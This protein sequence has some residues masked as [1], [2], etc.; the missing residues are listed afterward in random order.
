MFGFSP[1]AKS[2]NTEKVAS[3]Q[4]SRRGFIRGLGV[5]AASA[6]AFGGGALTTTAAKADATLDLEIL[7]FAL[8]LEY[9]EAE[10][11]LLAATGTGLAPADI[12][13]NP[14]I[15]TGGHKVSFQN[16]LVKAYAIE[17]AAEEQ[18]H[19]QFLR[20]AITALGGTPVSRPNIDLH[21]S[22]MTLGAAAGFN[23]DFRPFDNAN[24]FLLGS[25]IFED[26]GVTAYHAA[27]PLLSTTLL[28]DKASG[29]MAVEAYHSGII[30]TVLFAGGFD[31][32]TAAIS[33]LRATLDGTAGGMNV[34]DRGVG[35][36][37]AP[38]IVDCSNSLN[39]S[40]TGGLSNPPPGNNA[41][42]FNRSTTQVLQIVYGSPA[43]P[44]TPG[45]FFPQGMNG[46]I[47]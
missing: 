20:A 27:V 18:L 46:S 31:S 17:I 5:G 4:N 37:Q 35:T 25:Y 11:Y 34:D 22:F 40:L 44:P 6:M 10:F 28:Q 9:L 1:A 29:I 16:S 26:V 15:V 7:N 23:A 41:I 3:S 21:T 13:P 39:G 30:R 47:K 38:S 43:S 19:V 2:A 45:L 33:N 42:A 24:H 36:L 12:G 8:N 32:Q 14:G